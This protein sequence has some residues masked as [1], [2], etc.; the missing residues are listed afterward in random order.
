[1]NISVMMDLRD[2]IVV[3]CCLCVWLNVI[4]CQRCR[5][6][7]CVD[8]LERRNSCCVLFVCLVEC[9]KLEYINVP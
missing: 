1:M 3:V 9:F 2:V 7:N 4:H 5:D 8:G 6:F